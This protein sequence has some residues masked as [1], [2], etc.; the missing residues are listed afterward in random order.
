MKHKC[1]EIFLSISTKKT[2]RKDLF[3]EEDHL[4]IL[5]KNLALKPFFA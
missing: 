2:I 1:N 5:D 3:L 4:Q